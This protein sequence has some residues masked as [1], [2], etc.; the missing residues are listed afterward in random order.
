M[1]IRYLALATAVLMSTACD[2]D[3]TGPG[4]D[5]PEPIGVVGDDGG[6]VQ[7]DDGAVKLT[8]PP[9][10]VSGDTEITAEAAAPEDVPA[11][12]GLVPG[13]TYDFGPDGATFAEPVSIVLRY[14]PADLPAGVDPTS[15]ALHKAGPDGWRSTGESV[16]DV[17]ANTVTA[18][19]T[20]FSV[21][22]LLSMGGPESAAIE[23][24][25]GQTGPVGQPVTVPPAVLV[26]NGRGDPLADVTVT[27]AVSEGDG[28]VAE[29]SVTTDA[30]GLASP[31]AW[32]LG[33]EGSH[34]LTAT[35]EGLDPLVF[36]ATA[37]P[38]CDYTAPYVLGETVEGTLGAPDCV[39]AA[40]RFA[41]YH[42]LE[43]A[44]PTELTLT[45]TADGFDPVVGVYTPDG[46][47]V[48]AQYASSRGFTRAHLAPGVYRVGTRR[49]D[50]D[51]TT[52]APDSAG[53]YTLTV[54]Q[55]THT[56]ES[57]DVANNVYVTPGVTAT[58]TIST[59]HCPD[60]YSEDPEQRSMGYPT[61]MKAGHTYTY[62]LTADT[63]ALLS[64]WNAAG[65][66][67][68]LARTSQAGTVHITYT[69][70]QD[71][72]H[73]V[74]VLGHAG[75]GYELQV[76]VSETAVDR[77]A[78]GTPYVVGATN[79]GMLTAQS[80]L[81]GQGRHA[82]YYDLV[83]QEQL[84]ATLNMSSGDF[85]PFISAFDAEGRLVVTQYVDS[86]GFTRGVFAPGTYRIAARAADA[87]LTGWYDM[88]LQPDDHLVEACDL[89][90]N[91]F[92]TPGVTVGGR[93]TSADCVDELATEIGLHWDLYS[94]RL[95]PG[96]QVTVD[97]TAGAHARLSMW[98]PNG[99]N[100]AF[101][102][103]E[104]GGTVSIT[105]TADLEGWYSF[106][107]I[108][109]DGTDYTISVSERTSASAAAPARVEGPLAP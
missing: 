63:A 28:S 54:E 8:F 40:G 32:T 65:E 106:Y 97:L 76:E 80:C 107:A 92:V 23:A 101:E 77:C 29:T 93:I 11:D 108:A 59:G 64:L 45:M 36:T 49:M 109:Y 58:G 9:G 2:S 74:Y 79:E 39:D 102:A 24:G 1:R 72:F 48:V 73:G 90:A 47:Y 83:V 18:T 44:E 13:T 87:G 27:F 25:D 88:S 78:Q 62:T 61:A 42:H 69:A 6:A 105:V 20:G 38:A 95:M 57:C 46:R 16:V 31:S 104:T 67:A 53:A 37:V 52:V 98:N 82:E 55:A 33:S 75:L 99:E 100:T 30:S 91:V 22:G 56:A 43:L 94:V 81:D 21:Y 4:G 7:T 71:G 68:D 15:L 26:L 86:P 14:D 84:S 50:T 60:P 66:H 3:S 89:A 5:A 41:D 51:S 19:L 70:E 103:T 34:G 10:A 85:T 12:P 96:D 17:D 35:V